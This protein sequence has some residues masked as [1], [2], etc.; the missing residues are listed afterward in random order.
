MNKHPEAVSNSVDPA[1]RELLVSPFLIPRLFGSAT[2]LRR[3]TTTNPRR[4][5]HTKHENVAERPTGFQKND[6][7][8]VATET[9]ERPAT[10]P[11]LLYPLLGRGG[12]KKQRLL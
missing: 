3:V 8:K 12:G 7:H 11:V 6:K 4:R 10:S 5:L 1:T 9:E 2:D